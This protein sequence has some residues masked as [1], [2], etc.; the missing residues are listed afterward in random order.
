MK[1]RKKPFTTTEL[2]NIIN[3]QL[4]EKCVLPE[5]LDYGL[6]TREICNMLNYQFDI[7]GIVNF[8]SSEGIYLDVYAD[9]I[10][11]DS[12]TRKRFSLGTYKTL[13]EDLEAFK[14]MGALNAEFVFAARKFINDHLDDF[15]WSGFSVRF[16]KD[17]NDQYAYG[18]TYPSFA[19]AKNRIVRELKRPGA[20]VTRAVVINN[21]NCTYTEFNPNATTDEEL[22]DRFLYNCTNEQLE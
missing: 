6:A 4:K 20:S 15:E 14:V 3:E 11:D 2:F 18:Y 12:N 19:E 7:V 21:A 17:E 1:T 5:I 13:H 10:V 9:G 8:G 22:V 16:Y